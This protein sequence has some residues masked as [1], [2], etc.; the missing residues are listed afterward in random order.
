M[1]QPES[2]AQAAAGLLAQAQASRQRRALLLT[3]SS[4]WV[5]EQARLVLE[6]TGLAA[7]TGWLGNRTPPGISPTAPSKVSRLLGRELPALVVD[8][9]AGFDPDAV[10]A[11]VGALCGGGLFLLLTPPLAEWADYPDPEHARIAVA[12]HGPEAVSGRF[13]ERLAR[14]LTDSRELYRVEQGR[15][16]PALPAE[17]P[18]PPPVMI[19]PP[20]ATEDQ[21]TAVAALLR[22]ATGRARRPLVLIA[23]RGRG[24]SAAFGIAAAEL[25]AAGP[26]RLLLTG[27]RL[28]AVQGVFEHAGRL[29]PQAQRQGDT[30]ACGDGW[31]RFVAPDALA[32]E[33]PP[34]DLLLVD[35]AA[36]IP[37]PLLTRLLH[38]YPRIA[39]ATT[40]H[41]YE[42]TGRG[43]MLR[44]ARALTAQTPDWRRLRLEAPVRWAADDPV[45]RLSFRLLL[46][47]AEAAAGDELIQ[48]TPG[49]VRVELLEREAL[50]RDEV[51]L[52][53]LFGLLLQAHYRTRPFDLRHLL[54][55]PNVEIYAQLHAGRVV[56]AALVA[57]E[58]GL[59]AEIGTAIRRGERRLRGHLI[60]QSL[61]FHL[62][63]ADGPQLR[64]AR[65]MR[66]AVHPA[67]QRRGFGRQLVEAVVAA[68]AARG[69]DLVGSSFGGDAALLRFWQHS[70]LWPVRAGMT[71]T[72][73]SGEHALLVLRALSEPGRLLQA[74]ARRRFLRD[75]PDQLMQPLRELEPTLVIR[76]LQGREASLL[77]DAVDREELALFAFMQR[78]YGD[79]IG[80]LRRG[81]LD[82]LA[83]PPGQTKLS[84]AQWELLVAKVL[85]GR[86]WSEVVRLGAFAGRAE[87]LAELRR[88]VGLLLGDD[89]R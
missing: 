29:L 46:L 79:T 27:P 13:L 49:Q 64:C 16:L 1:L 20:Y 28:E 31:L 3:G 87:A 89:P 32:A 63:L 85:Q 88:A 51:R 68:A 65:I 34:A 81:L 74:E 5:F 47:D 80:A 73:S 22:L 38:H 4:D 62:G 11:A 77:A 2:I 57:L 44:F 8:A 69:L 36:A 67:C 72:S 7:T 60:P 24:K 76:L 48:I 56:G 61:A 10:G 33:L 70:G 6:T 18:A 43:F 82:A 17:V 37:V 52:S 35:E 30:L 83:R 54:D 53:E 84:A 41:G 9:Y 71:R 42:G 58:G 39:F 21:R 14:L 78:S 50:A 19:A 12:P 45:E 23:D 26:R 86:S 40:V 15:P 59:D 55:G 75:L 25:L 66:L